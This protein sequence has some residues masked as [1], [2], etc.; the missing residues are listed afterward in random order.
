MG[1]FSKV[2]SE[3]ND[4]PP[5]FQQEK[6]M[7]LISGLA[8]IKSPRTSTMRDRKLTFDPSTLTVLFPCLWLSQSSLFLICSACKQLS[9][10]WDLCLPTPILAFSRLPK[11]ISL[12]GQMAFSTPMQSEFHTSTANVLFIWIYPIQY[13][14]HIYT[15]EGLLRIISLKFRPDCMPIWQKS[16][17]YR[18]PFLSHFYSVT[19]LCVHGTI[20]CL[21]AFS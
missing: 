11:C 6:V 21:L 16:P 10:G 18:F 5:L 4:F 9:L 17:K 3:K 13:L 14:E 8:F 1:F 15:K 7:Q 2:F 19:H 12:V 20:I